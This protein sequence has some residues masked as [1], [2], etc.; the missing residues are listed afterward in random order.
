MKLQLTRPNNALSSA[1]RALPLALG[2]VACAGLDASRVA[3]SP[4][5]QLDAV[6]PA[7]A[8]TAPAVAAGVQ[9]TEFDLSL[10]GDPKFQRRFTESYVAETDIEPRVTEQERT[11]LQ[12]ILELIS[13][14]KV[15]KAVAQLQK[16]GG[17]GASAV[18]DFT[19]AN[20]YFQQDE[21]YQASVSYT[22]AVEKH[23][24]FRRA[25][26]NLALVHVRRGDF[27][28][29][30]A[31]FARV[32]EL[33][34]GDGV[35]YGLL[36][37]A[38]TNLEQHMSAESAYRMAVLLDPLTP[39]WVTGLARTFFK[40]KRYAEAVTLCGSLIEKDP[41]RADM[42]LLQANAFIGLEQPMRAAQNFEV[43]DRL[44]AATF[45]S[46]TTLGDIYVNEQLFDVGVRS[47]LRAFE[48]KPDGD[49]SRALRA[50]KSLTAQGARAEC[51]ALVDGLQTRLGERMSEG[52][53]KDLLK[54]RARLASAQGAGEEEARILEEILALDP[55]DGEAL[56]LLAQRYARN[57]EAERAILFYERAANL[58]GSEA[59][60]K[61]QHGRLLVERGRY[62]EALPL[63]R[64]SLDVRPRENVRKYVEQIERAAQS[65]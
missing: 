24:K 16:Y 63:L 25:W 55:L 38:Y 32:I 47:Y 19:L 56:I 64:R 14:E 12:Q 28:D 2:C 27:E 21:L 39:D 42:W 26:K 20:L 34:G 49:A 37:F 10:W 1:V 65:R 59:E 22:D 58:E 3:P 40:Q 53:R 17:P 7:F 50:A 33:G 11:Q 48:V 31:A 61:L 54:I 62:A 13:G 15:D 5:A 52:E 43:V 60:A 57:D 51:A 36:G 35:T 41:N 4:G 6:A 44:G 46:L 9:W 8:A 45:E 30:A 29:A 18:F 23:P